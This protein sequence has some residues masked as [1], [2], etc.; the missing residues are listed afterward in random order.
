[1]AITNCSNGARD[2]GHATGLDEATADQDATSECLRREFV[3]N[4]KLRFAVETGTSAFKVM[5][6]FG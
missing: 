1:M 5:F 2:Y 6:D 4:G 3:F